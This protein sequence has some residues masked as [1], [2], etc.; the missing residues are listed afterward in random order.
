MQRQINADVGK[1]RRISPVGTY[2][3]SEISLRQ[4][5]TTLDVNTTLENTVNRPAIPGRKI[6]LNGYTLDVFPPSIT[7][8]NGDPTHTSK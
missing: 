8:T 7:W 3:K 2:F 4:K 6:H 5:L 1:H